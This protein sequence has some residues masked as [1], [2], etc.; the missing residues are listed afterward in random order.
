MSY[1]D[2]DVSEGRRMMNDDRENRL[3]I[4]DK[5][6]SVTASGQDG[7]LDQFCEE[8]SLSPQT[9]RQYATLHACV[10]RPDGSS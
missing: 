5:L 3:V 6:L 8:I 9:A 10:P 1:T 2:Q 4:D 7:V